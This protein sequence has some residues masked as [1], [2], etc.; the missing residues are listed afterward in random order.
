MA[1]MGL[2]EESFRLPI[3][4]PKADS[5]QKIVKTLRD[6]GLLRGALV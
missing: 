1:A 5:K 2:L 3:V 4:P 6:L